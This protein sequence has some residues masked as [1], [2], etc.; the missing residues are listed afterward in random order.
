[1]PHL[2]QQPR[3]TPSDEDLLREIHLVDEQGNYWAGAPALALALQESSMPIWRGV[4]R[5]MNWP[6]IRPMAQFGYRLVAKNRRRV[7]T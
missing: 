1:M 3:Y 6:L 5:A 2:A 7:A 4:G